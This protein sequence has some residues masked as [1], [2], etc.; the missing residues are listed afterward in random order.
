MIR[1]SKELKKSSNF[2]DIT[3]YKKS[4]EKLKETEERYRTLI[5]NVN[6]AFLLHES[7][8]I[9]LDVNQKACELFGYEKKQLVGKPLSEFT[10]EESMKDLIPNM[11][12][13]LETGSLVFDSLNSG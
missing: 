11:E 10:S 8:G 1:Y 3:K 13:L 5:E 2:T 6:D 9:I 12:R 4:E 7:E